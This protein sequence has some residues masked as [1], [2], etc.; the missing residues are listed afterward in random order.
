LANALHVS[1]IVAH[2][3]C[4]IT[5]LGTGIVLLRPTAGTRSLLFR[6]YLG[7]LW[8]MVLFLIAAVALDW[9]ALARGSQVLYSLLL[10]LALY[11][12]WRG[13][14]ALQHLRTRAGDWHVGYIEDVGFT[15]IALFDG[16]VIISALDLDAPLWLV[17]VIAALGILSGRFGVQQAHKAADSAA[18]RSLAGRYH[19]RSG[20]SP[21]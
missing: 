6:V 5:A 16:F 18:R 8:L 14:S 11:V 10:L 20:A 13:W 4:G 15:V 1:L 7:A 17:L 19:E 2:A 9:P 3:V 12:G 21:G